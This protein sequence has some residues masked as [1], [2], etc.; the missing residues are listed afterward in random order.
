MCV[1][2]LE[3]I[4]LKNTKVKVI[5][6]I[7][8]MEQGGAQQIL[9]NALRYFKCNQHIDFSLYVLDENKGS[10][11][12]KI[13]ER[14]QLKV[15]YVGNMS[16]KI[17]IWGIRR[18]LMSYQICSAIDKIIQKE[19]P[20][21]VHIH[22][23]KL[24]AHAASQ[25]KKHKEVMFFD[26]LHSDPSRYQG[27]DLTLLKKCFNKYG[28]IP[29]CVTDYQVKRAKNHYTLQDVELVRNS[30]EIAILKNKEVSKTEAREKLGFPKNVYIVG[31]VGRLNAI[32]RYDFL[33]ETFA[34]LKKQK[35]E[36]MLIFA[37]TGPEQQNLVNLAKEYGISDSVV[38]LGMIENMAE[39]YCSIDVL[40]VT[41]VSESC[42][43]VA[44]EAQVF[45]RK[46]VI[47]NGVPD[48]VIVSDNVIRMPESATNE[49]WKEALLG[50][51]DCSPK[52]QL[53]LE[54]YDI[55]TTQKHLEELYIKY[56]TIK[57]S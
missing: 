56:A 29:V 36:A 49:Q 53:S 30:I 23:S 14:E 18:L 8:G 44:L 31:A 33:M 51:W 25:I 11:Y 48:S 7:N 43:L 12:D 4:K 10:K 19:K 6:F 9:I 37:G 3:E 13:I 55:D 28:V 50:N 2:A 46:C 52:G 39:V 57:K 5:N 45:E 20:D 27:Y 34:L 15:T 38:F 1:A 16:S 41:S 17:N 35:N 21:I 42:S 26:T 22:I 24:L 40:A 47:S 32:K 54:D